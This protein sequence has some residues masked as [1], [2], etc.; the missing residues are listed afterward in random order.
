[1]NTT[2]LH[3]LTGAY[4]LHALND[5]ERAAFER[6]LTTCDG[7]ELEVAEFTATAGRLALAST[8][9]TRPVMREQVLQRITTVRQASPRTVPLQRM[10]RG[11]RRGRGLAQWAL[12]AS[13]AAAAALGGTAVWQYERAQD[14]QNQASQAQRHVEDLAGV[15]AA[16]DAKSRSVKV[17]GGAGTLVVS[18]SRD[19]AVFV[20][21]K[22][23]AP[24]RGKV[25]QLWFADGGKMRAAGLMDP[26]RSSQAVVMQGAVDGASGVG[27]TVEPAGGSKQPTSTPVALLGV[28]T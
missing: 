26:D 1:M 4:A 18:A 3:G 28:P 12:A 19:R 25:Y 10:P 13:V 21:S 14:A 2:D 6:H 20:A 5:E 11:A 15:L 24:P 17:A 23:P 16:P 9:R 22:M 7:C 8:V 27:I